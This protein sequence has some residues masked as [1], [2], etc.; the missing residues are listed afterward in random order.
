MTPDDA[1]QLA[2][3]HVLT[4][5]THGGRVRPNAP[6]RWTAP[7]ERTPGWVQG[8]L[9]APIR[10]R[11]GTGEVRV[12]VRVPRWAGGRPWVRLRW[13][14]RPLGYWWT[15]RWQLADAEGLQ[16]DSRLRAALVDAGRAVDRSVIRTSLNRAWRTERVQPARE[17]AFLSG[18]KAV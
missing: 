12:T 9:V 10:G 11:L 13:T 7:L 6:A 8:R 16:A 1:V 3:D 4:V 15:A 5:L 17:R 18:L 2:L 14:R